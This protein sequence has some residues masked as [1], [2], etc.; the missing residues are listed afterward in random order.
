MNNIHNRANGSKT[1]DYSP[2]DYSKS[3]AYVQRCGEEPCLKFE[4]TG[5]FYRISGNW[6]FKTREGVNYGPYT[7]KTE[8]RY[9][10]NEFIDIV[11]NNQSLGG[12]DIGF[13]DEETTFKI[14]KITLG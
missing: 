1:Q 6:F 12:I 3:P 8:C 7:D 2:R 14:P 4:R 9:A 10:Y 11:N 13:N 5:R